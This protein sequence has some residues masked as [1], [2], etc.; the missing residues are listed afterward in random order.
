MDT[1]AQP[2]DL[3][4][5]QQASQEAS[6]KAGE[7][8]WRTQGALQTPLQHFITSGCLP[9]APRITRLTMEEFS[10]SGISMN[11]AE[12]LQNPAVCSS[13]ALSTGSDNKQGSTRLYSLLP[14]EIQRCASILGL[15]KSRMWSLILRWNVKLIW[16]KSTII[17]YIEVKPVC[18]CVLC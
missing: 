8:G 2:Q 5:V 6:S 10:R 15:I 13:A 4:I 16:T 3:C 18:L 1:A 12:V 14:E 7:A 9:K 17:H 11:G